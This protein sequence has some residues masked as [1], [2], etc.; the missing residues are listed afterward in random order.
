[1]LLL[2]VLTSLVVQQ[3]ADDDDDRSKPTEERDLVAVNKYRQP[4]R[5]R[6]LHRVA[7]TAK[8]I[9]TRTLKESK[10]PSG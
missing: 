4:D 3:N 7:Y 6:P 1:M 8:H 2:L 5:R 10:P 9:N